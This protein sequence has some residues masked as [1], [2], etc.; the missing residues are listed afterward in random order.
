MSR[1]RGS[2]SAIWRGVNPRFTSLRSFVW[3][4]GSWLIRSSPAPTAAVFRVLDH[5]VRVRAERLRVAR[6][7]EHVRRSR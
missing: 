3:R 7:L 1:T 5:R 6:H 2:S 4:G